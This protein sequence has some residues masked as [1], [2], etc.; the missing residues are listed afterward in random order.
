M[1]FIILF[2]LVVTFIYSIPGKFS[3][4]PMDNFTHIGTLHRGKLT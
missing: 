3:K 4:P 2:K 1:N